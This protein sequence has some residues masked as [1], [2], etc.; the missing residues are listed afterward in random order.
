MTA[1]TTRRPVRKETFR[2]RIVRYWIMLATVT[3]V[4]R[5]R[6]FQSKVITV[7][8]G[9]VALAQLGRDNQARPLRRAASWY[10]MVGVRQELGRVAETLELDRIAEALE[11]DRIAEALEPDTT[12]EALEPGKSSKPN[13]R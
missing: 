7:A 1:E 12:A 11:L 5:D 10:S 4:L 2:Q 9:A 13:G 8:I 6:R 3:H